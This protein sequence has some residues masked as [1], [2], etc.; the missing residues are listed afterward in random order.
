LAV[1]FFEVLILLPFVLG[2]YVGLHAVVHPATPPN[3]EAVFK[4]RYRRVEWN[5]RNPEDFTRKVGGIVL[6]ASVLYGTLILL[7][8]LLR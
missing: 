6:A 5:E 2:L 3:F 1:I 7:P 8:W 4:R